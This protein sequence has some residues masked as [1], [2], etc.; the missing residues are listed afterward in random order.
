VGAR[1]LGALRSP[2]PYVGGCSTRC[3][4]KVSA[5]DG[6]AQALSEE[7]VYDEDGNPVTATFADYGSPLRHSARYPWA[8]LAP[9]IWR[10]CAGWQ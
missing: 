10:F 4:R 3:S 9:P 1:L 5:H 7:V 2:Y 6:V 8:T